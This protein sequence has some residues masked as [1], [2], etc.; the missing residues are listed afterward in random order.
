MHIKE[1]E[2]VALHF[3]WLRKQKFVLNKPYLSSIYFLINIFNF[4]CTQILNIILCVFKLSDFN[5]SSISDFPPTKLLPV[6]FYLLSS[7]VFVSKLFTA[8]VIFDSLYL[9]SFIHL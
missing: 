9:S 4:N 6:S 5:S 1:L 2:P 3:N 8:L 7:R